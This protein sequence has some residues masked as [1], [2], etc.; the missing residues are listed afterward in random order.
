MPDDA[1]L[2]STLL[3]ADTSH[4]RDTVLELC[5][6]SPSLSRAVMR[7]LAPE[8]SFAKSTLKPVPPD[9]P[10]SGSSSIPLY[11]SSIDQSSLPVEAGPSRHPGASPIKRLIPSTPS[12]NRQPQPLGSTSVKRERNASAEVSFISPSRQPEFRSPVKLPPQASSSSPLSSV[13]SSGRKRQIEMNCGICVRCGDVFSK[14]GRSD[15]EQCKYHTGALEPD[16]DDEYW[17]DT[18]PGVHDVTPDHETREHFIWSC[19]SE[20]GWHAGCQTGSHLAKSGAK[21]PRER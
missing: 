18:D 14:D 7:S 6:L 1:E 21:K 16:W 10:R 15:A 3:T 5:K 17:C 20:D 11:S 19:C 4:L 8:S 13:S 2:R 12:A 9:F